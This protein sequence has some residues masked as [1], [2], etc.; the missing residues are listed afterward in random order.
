MFAALYNRKHVIGRDLKKV[1]GYTLIELMIV[2]VILG[3]LAAVSVAGYTR[4][5]RSSHYA[6]AESAIVDILAKQESYFSTWGKFKSATPHPVSIPE[7]GS[8][9]WAG[10]NSDWQSLGFSVSQ[11]TRWQYSVIPAGAN[12]VAV[13][14]L[15]RSNGEL[16]I[17][18]ASTKNQRVRTNDEL[19][20]V[21]AKQICTE[22]P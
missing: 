14:A 1:G 2:V 13:I 19:V 11:P 10:G 15:S 6:E 7:N 20:G 18:C 22:I 21:T 5:I 8:V 9:Q 17:A 16:Q 4:Y 3:L 12:A